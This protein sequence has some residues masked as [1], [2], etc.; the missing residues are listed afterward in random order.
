[1]TRPLTLTLEVLSA[2]PGG[3][4]LDRG[5]KE[6]P[7]ILPSIACFDALPVASSA[8]DPETV[9]SCCMEDEDIANSEVGVTRKVRRIVDEASPDILRLPVGGNN[10]LGLFRA[11]LHGFPGPHLPLRPVICDAVLEFAE[12]KALECVTR[13]LTTRAVLVHPFF[14]DH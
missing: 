5:N 14:G 10:E 12:C 11:D 1:M 6:I 4:L 8:I 7:A 9:V 2:N 13:R 3:F